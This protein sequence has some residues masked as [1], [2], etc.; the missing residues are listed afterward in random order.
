MNRPGQILRYQKP[1]PRPSPRPVCGFVW[2]L[3]TCL[4]A[5][6]IGLFAYCTHKDKPVMRVSAEPRVILHE[7]EQSITF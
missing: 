1:C 5:L 7:P 3:L 6:G 2:A 4:A